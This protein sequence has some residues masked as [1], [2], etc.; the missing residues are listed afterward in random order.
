MERNCPEMTIRACS[1]LISALLLATA[2]GAATE[3]PSNQRQKDL[4][5]LL[6]ADCGSCH[7]MTMKGGLGPPLLPADLVGKPDDYLFA[8]IR[9]GRA[10]TPM[11]PWHQFLSDAE[12]RWMIDVLRQEKWKKE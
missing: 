12:I 2:C 10:G 5:H 3:A 9:D 4:M 7:G 6:L 11:P 8:V 1:A